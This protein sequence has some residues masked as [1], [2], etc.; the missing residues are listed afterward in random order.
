MATSNKDQ[1]DR[2]AAQAITACERILENLEKLAAK[3]EGK[4]PSQYADVTAMMNFAAEL[5]ELLSDF[6]SKRM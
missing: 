5:H 4:A 6:Y 3:Y 1:L 2:W